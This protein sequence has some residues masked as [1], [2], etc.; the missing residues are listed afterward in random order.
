MEVT[1]SV[2]KRHWFVTPT[3]QATLGLSAVLCRSPT[4]RSRGTS[5]P[6]TL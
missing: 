3:I 1:I 2:A 4:Q 6:P 5:G